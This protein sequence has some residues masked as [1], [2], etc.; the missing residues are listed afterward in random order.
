MNRIST[1]EALSS[2]LTTNELSIEVTPNQEAHIS[3]VS[4]IPQIP[5][6]LFVENVTLFYVVLLRLSVVAV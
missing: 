1:T 4:P 2:T 3:N 6:N 5:L